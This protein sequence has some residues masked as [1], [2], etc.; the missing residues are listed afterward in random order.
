MAIDT[1]ETL[2]ERLVAAR[3]PGAPRVTPDTE[4]PGG[5]GGAYRV[6]A[7]VAARLGPVGGFKC[8]RKA[9]DGVLKLAPVRAAEVR[10]DGVELPGSASGLHLVELEVAFRLFADPPPVDDPR[11]EAL[12]RERVEVLPAL[13]IVDSR[14]DDFTA[15]PEAWQLADDQ[16]AGGIVLGTRSDGADDAGLVERDVRLEIGGQEVHAGPAAFPGGDAFATFA[17][18]VR[19]VGAHCGG[20][21]AGQACITGALTGP[22]PARAGDEIRGSID[23]LG[24]VGA[25]FAPDV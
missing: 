12:L 1:I 5:H 16:N 6:Q 10:T 3:T 18:F 11:F 9:P 13:E 17:A 25:R 2:V 20:L 19:T 24:T 23:G 22:H 21:R 8:G 15:A 7:G 14:L 4:L